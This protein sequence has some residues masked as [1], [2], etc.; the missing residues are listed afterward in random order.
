MPVPH[1]R[2]ERRQML[3]FPFAMVLRMLVVLV[4]AM[5]RCHRQA[6]VFVNLLVLLGEHRLRSASR[7]CRVDSL[8]EGGE[9]TQCIVHELEKSRPQAKHQCEAN[10]VFTQEGLL[11]KIRLSLFPVVS[12]TTYEERRSLMSAKMKVIDPRSPYASTNARPPARRT[13]T[14]KRSQSFGNRASSSFGRQSLF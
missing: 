14:I 9:E 2:V 13:C 3:M 8:R 4:L 10:R 1:A 6:I 5:F 12:Q 11:E 7:R